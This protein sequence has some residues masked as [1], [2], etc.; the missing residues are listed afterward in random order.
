[1]GQIVADNVQRRRTYKTGSIE[2]RGPGVYRL[3]VVVKDPNTHR[4]VRKSKT[5]RV[6]ERGGK[7]QLED[8]LARFRTEVGE[9]SVIGSK[10]TVSALLDD[11]LETLG[12]GDL[13]LNTVESY[14]S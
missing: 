2:P 14:T 1:M 12:R 5:V 10:A 3:R 6:P 4:L 9:A 7:R 11:W 13:A 8:E